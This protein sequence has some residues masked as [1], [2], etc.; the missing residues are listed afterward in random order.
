MNDIDP[1]ARNRAVR[2]ELILVKVKAELNHFRRTDGTCAFPPPCSY[3]DVITEVDKDIA[4]LD[5]AAA[6][7]ESEAAL[8]AYREGT[9]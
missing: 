1:L 3:C 4:F 9:K 8:R 2:D 6:R 5:E 7:A